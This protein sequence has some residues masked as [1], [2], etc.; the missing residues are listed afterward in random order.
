MNT[1]ST[2]LGFDSSEQAQF[3][4]HVLK[5]FYEGGW[6]TVKLAFPHIKRP[7]LYRWKKQYEDSG[8]RLNSLIPKSTKPHHYRQPKEHLA[9][10]KLV[11]QLREAHPR[12]GKMKIEQFVKITGQFDVIVSNVFDL[13]HLVNL[14]ISTVN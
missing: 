12:M 14:I 6:D 10:T 3:R 7:T 4:F 8:K 13:F 9:V 1:L 5:V 11:K 2:I